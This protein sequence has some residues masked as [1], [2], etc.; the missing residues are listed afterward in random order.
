MLRVKL[1]GVGVKSSC[2]KLKRLCI[3]CIGNRKTSIQRKQETE[4]T[5]STES[6]GRRVS[7][8]F[9]DPRWRKRSSSNLLGKVAGRKTVWPPPEEELK[10]CVTASDGHDQPSAIKKIWSPKEGTVTGTATA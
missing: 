5:L 10:V 6:V 4:T 3:S 1:Q 2:S 9:A 7:E 8:D